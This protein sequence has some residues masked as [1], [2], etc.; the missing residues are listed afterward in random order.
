MSPPG[1]HQLGSFGRG[2]KS[3]TSLR[4]VAHIRNY[5]CSLF[6]LPNSNVTRRQRQIPEQ[7]VGGG[8]SGLWG[9]GSL[10]GLL[11]GV[12]S[13]L[14]SSSKWWRRFKSTLRGTGSPV[15]EG[16]ERPAADVLEVELHDIFMAV[17]T[18]NNINMFTMG[19]PPLPRFP[20][21]LPAFFFFFSHTHA[22]RWGEKK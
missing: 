17:L 18:V 6:G 3:P 16:G 19:S 11:T 21:Q 7:Q 12:L 22:Q 1:Q 20:P 4:S 10:E 13:V 14:T 15:S 9:D 8:A 5:Y 2:Q